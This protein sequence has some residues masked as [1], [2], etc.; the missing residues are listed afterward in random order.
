MSLAFP[1]WSSL[2]GHAEDTARRFPLVILAAT[3][4]TVAAVVLVDNSSSQQLFHLLLASILGLSWLSALYLAAERLGNAAGL[5]RH[6]LPAIGTLFL[7]GFGVLASGAPEDQV[8]ARFL[9]WALIGHLAVAVLPYLR[10]G[11]G[12]WQFNRILFQRALLAAV[13]TGALGIGL[14]L[15]LAAIDKL[16]G[17]PIDGD[18]YPQLLVVLAFSFNT[19]FLLAGVPRDFAELER[20]ND[21]PAGL[22][23]FAQHVLLPLVAIY[24]LILTLYLG[25]VV[26]TGTWPQG[27]IGV[28]VSGVALTGMLA[29]LL[30]HPLR[31][32]APG[33]WVDRAARG[34]FAGLVPTLIMALLAVGKRIGQYGV[35]EPRYAL[36]VLA[37]WLLLLSVFYLVS[38]SRSIRLIPASLGVVAVL[39]AFGPW[40]IFATSRRS[41][42]TR[43]QAI[44]ARNGLVPGQ[45]VTDSGRAL[46][47]TDRRE[48]AATLHYLVRRHGPAAVAQAT[49]MP[50]DSLSGTLGG[51]AASTALERLGL[52]DPEPSREDY[53]TVALTDRQPD[54]GVAIGAG[55]YL[56]A[57]DNLFGQL[58]LRLV[59]A[60]DTVTMTADSANATAL[61]VWRAGV[62]FARLAIGD[63]MLAA[64]PRPGDFGRHR[65]GPL[66]INSQTLPVVRL[67][68]TEGNWSPGPAG[69][70]PPPFIRAVIIIAPND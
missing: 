5:S 69:S 62:R 46:S 70:S 41:Q 55:A 37:G 29:L 59:Y 4:A 49:G 23:V 3:A 34:F 32:T 67:I 6:A 22:R 58:P 60:G 12:F 56:Y 31:L 15:A 35:T 44:G 57:R 17:V 20:L 53:V 1:S 30:L 11:R 39:A 38:R 27:W 36:A 33:R 48:L 54:V 51:N 47:A 28:L 66:V 16:L 68:V 64:A 7:A 18:R 40:G 8:L 10:R 42:S 9:H 45:P 24:L 26:V 21:Y 25:R 52:R 65:N 2:R 14:S 63:S 13:Y 43:F 19:W 61:T 50:L